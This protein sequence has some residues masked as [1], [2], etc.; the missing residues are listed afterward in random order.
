MKERCRYGVPEN[1]SHCDVLIR[2]RFPL[3]PRAV[4]PHTER[5]EEGKGAA[6]RDGADPCIA[7]PHAA[8]AAGSW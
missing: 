6:R 4:N 2:R 3:Q 7:Q 1:V 5:G 8:A